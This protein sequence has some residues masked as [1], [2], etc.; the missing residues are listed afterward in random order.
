MALSL[1]CR[2]CPERPRGGPEAERTTSA[3]ADAPVRALCRSQFRP[4]RA[5][6]PAPCFSSMSS[7]PFVVRFSDAGV[8]GW[9]SQRL[10]FEPKV[11]T[12]REAVSKVAELIFRGEG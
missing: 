8:G 4:R 5:E 1:D 3:E 2:R 11:W 9:S 7:L 6:Q 12:A 10:P